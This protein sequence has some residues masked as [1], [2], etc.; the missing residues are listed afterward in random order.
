[1][2]SFKL[3]SARLWDYIARNVYSNMLLVETKTNIIQAE[4]P[5]GQ[6]L[7]QGFV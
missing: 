4:W 1:M 5:F 7:M 2:A 6:I 3:E